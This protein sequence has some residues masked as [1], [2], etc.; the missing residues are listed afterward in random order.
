MLNY[1]QDAT[2][3][4]PQGTEIQETTLEQKTILD[5]DD[6]TTVKKKTVARKHQVS[7]IVIAQRILWFVVG[8]VNA[9]IALRFIFLLFGANQEAGFTGVIYAVSAPFVAPFVGI[10]GEPVLG[11]LVIEASSLLAIVIYLLV[12]WII[13]KILTVT[14]PQY[15]I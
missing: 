3:E 4:P 7:R 1:T 8:L 10:F 6:N 5:E 15:E 13:S 14:R 9:V 12:G 2:Q 11:D